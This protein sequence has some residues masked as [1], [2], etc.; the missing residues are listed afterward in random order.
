MEQPKY[1]GIFD[2][3][4]HYDDERFQDDQ[5]DVF[6]KI[7]QH[8]VSAVINVGC[9]LST[10]Q[11]VIDLAEKYPQF[12]CSVGIHPHDAANIPEDYLQQLTQMSKHQKVVAIGEIGL[13]YHYD[14]PSRKQQLVVFEQQ[15]QLAKQLQLPVIIHSRDATEDTLKLLKQY[16]PQGVV[17]CFSGSAQT[18][19]EIV[20]LGM[21]LG[22]TGVLTFQNAKRAQQAVEVTTTDR[23]LLETDCPYMAPVPYRGKRCDSSMI[24]FTAEK[25]A[26]IK[27]I[28]TQQMIDFARE[29]TCRLFQITL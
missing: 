8:G 14:S 15:L 26:Q 19:K 21:Y 27:G 6:E 1:H 10:C 13:D 5:A 11:S 29:N 28:S 16:K 7:K 9:N 23:L 24:A 12:Y 22:F 18:A 20:S 2:S 25:M 3:H 4:A 17:H